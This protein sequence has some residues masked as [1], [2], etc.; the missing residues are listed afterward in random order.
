MMYFF[1]AP[2]KIVT[3]PTSQKPFING[4]SNGRIYFEINSN[5]AFPM[6]RFQW[7]FRHESANTFMKLDG[8]ISQ[9]LIF[10]NFRYNFLFP[11]SR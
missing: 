5:D 2:V 1:V 8:K 3:Q 4:Q 6:P 10:Q 7:F 11:F 9:T